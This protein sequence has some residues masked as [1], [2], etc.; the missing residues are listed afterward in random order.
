MK[1]KIRKFDSTLNLIQYLENNSLKKNSFFFVNDLNLRFQKFNNDC[2]YSKDKLN[3]KINKIILINRSYI[4]SYNCILK[5][6]NK[7]TSLIRDKDPNSFVIIHGDHGAHSIGDKNEISNSRLFNFIGF[8][9]NESCP[10]S[11]DKNI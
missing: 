3:E 2:N 8:K 11:N 10:L 1:N 6:I 9:S 4:N 7:I 5:R